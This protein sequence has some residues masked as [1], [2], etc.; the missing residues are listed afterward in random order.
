MHAVHK[1]S[2]P[3]PQ[4]EAARYRDSYIPVAWK[5]TEITEIGQNLESQ[6]IHENHGFRNDCWM[7]LFLWVL[8]FAIAA[9]ACGSLWLHICGISLRQLQ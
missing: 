3:P 7:L 2:P 6:K 5:I 9:A 8:L 4:P 1:F